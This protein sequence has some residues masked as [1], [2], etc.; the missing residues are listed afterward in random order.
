MIIFRDLSYNRLQQWRGNI[1][2]VLPSL[3]SVNF[4]GNQFFLP[5]KNLLRLDSLLDIYGIVWSTACGECYLIRT[6]LLKSFNDSESPCILDDEYYSFADEIKYGKSLLFVREGFSPQC[7]CEHKDCDMTEKG[8]PY[9]M[10]LNTLPRKLF[11]VEY[12]FGSTAVV[13]NFVVVLITFGS[14]SMRKST[15]FVLIGNIG[16]CDILM[17]IY[18]ILIGRFTVYEFIVNESHYPDTDTFVNKYCTIM[19][20]IFT[21]AQITSVSTSFLATLERY[22]SIVYCMNPQARLR[23]TTALWCLVAIWSAAIAFSLLPVFQ[24]GGLRYH[25]EFTCMMPFLNGPELTDTS[26]TGFAVASLL[27]LFYLVSFAMYFH[28]F[29]HVRK[30]GISAGVKRKAS[31][32]KNILKMVLTNFLFF[33]IPMVCTLLFVYKYKDLM[34]AFNVDSLTKLRIYFIMLSWLP[35]VFLSVNSCLNPFLCAFRHPKFRGELHAFINRCK[36]NCFKTS[37]NELF[38][39]WTLKASKRV[40]LNCT[41][42]IVREENFIDRYRS[43][44]TLTSKL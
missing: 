8:I 31:L 32:A 27:V 26:M 6:E 19:G 39:A 38:E 14:Q 12:V 20:V 24:V 3:E 13:L 4:T 21:G 42:A 17:G 11:Y 15:S 36:C 41:D 30:A 16:L 33:V 40:D 28:I 37:S 34:E 44:G 25:G 1:S 29:L 2:T 7:L 5:D 35:V 18:S 43:L 22:L 23:K 9:N 10:A